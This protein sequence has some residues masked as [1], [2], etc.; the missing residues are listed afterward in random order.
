MY[1]RHQEGIKE[2]VDDKSLLTLHVE[3]EVETKLSLRTNPGSTIRRGAS[4]AGS[5]RAG[6][7]IR[8]EGTE[9]S[10]IR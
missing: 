9:K 10:N 6:V 5:T 1:G 4:G 7:A 2:T 8:P 3:I